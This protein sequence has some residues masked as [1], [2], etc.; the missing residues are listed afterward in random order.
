[1]KTIYSK[2]LFFSLM[3]SALNSCSLE[4]KANGFMSTE[5]FYKTADDALSGL[6]YA[7]AAIPSYK[8]FSASYMFATCCPT[9]EFT[10]KSD[11]GTTQHDLDR[12]QQ[13][14]LTNT[15]TKDCFLIAYL[16]IGRA[17][18]LIENI[19]DIAMDGNLRDQ[20]LGEAY[21]LRAYSYFNLVRLFGK[22]PLRLE[23]L[24]D[25]ENV[26]APL[27]SIEDIYAKSIIPDLQM[28][29]TLM[30]AEKRRGRV[31]KVGAQGLLADVYLFLA[32]A[33][34]SGLEGYEF[35]SSSDEYYDLAEEKAREVVYPDTPNGY[36]FDDSYAN[37]FNVTVETSPELIFYTI[38]SITTVGEK[39]LASTLITPYCNEQSFTVPDQY[40]GFSCWYGWEHV[41][42]EIPFYDSF[43]DNDK[44]KDAYFCTEIQVGDK[45]HSWKDGQ[46]YIDGVPDENGLCK[47]PFVTK[48]LD[49][50]ADGD[51]GN[52]H[53]VVRYSEVLLTFAE[54]AGNTP[55]GIEALNTIR[56]RAGL[57]EYTQGDFVDDKDFRKA[58]VQERAWELCYEFYRLYDLRRTKGMEEM[59]QQYGKTLVKNYYFY[60]IPQ[61]EI[62]YNPGLN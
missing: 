21:F 56:R 38:S 12:N 6:M 7:Y 24:K 46:K 3:V 42:V 15:E 51:T 2:I 25:Y 23:S 45:V 40:G 57:D 1:M 61:E 49:S 4:E 58:V 36:G 13:D 8:N 18:T 60:A 55:E 32:S 26:G 27:A 50:N 41:W 44:R 22:V 30:D 10:L 29:E 34:E 54:A 5:N 11:A 28:A 39:N 14:G 52:R 16:V 9:E 47:R 17:N 35:V 62:D 59:A 48:Y 20:M 43:A 53:P 33:K 31:N 19:P 37:I